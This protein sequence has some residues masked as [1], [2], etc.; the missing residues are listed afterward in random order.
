MR[1]TDVVRLGVGAVAL[2]R[3][4][5]PVRVAGAPG[6]GVVRTVVRVL[7]ARYVV[8]SVLPQVDGGRLRGTWLRG[9][10]AAVDGLHAASMV[11]LAA[12]APSYRRLA[13]GSAALATGLALADVRTARSG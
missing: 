12:I 10:D 2:A 3:P 4:Q 11:G 8:Q 13:L 6:G 7:A 5:L 1:G 9:G